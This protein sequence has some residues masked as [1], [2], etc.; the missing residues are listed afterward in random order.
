VL[1]TDG[2][3]GALADDHHLAMGSSWVAGDA[4]YKLLAEADLVLGIGTNFSSFMTDDWKLP[5]PRRLIHLDIDQREVGKNYPTELTLLGDARL[6]L[7]AMSQVLD[8]TAARPPQPGRSH[9]IREAKAQA[10]ARAEQEAASKSW[11]WDGSVLGVLD[12]IRDVVPRN[13]ILML[14]SQ[15][16]YWVARHYPAYEPRTVHMPMAYGSLGFSLPAAIGA[17][18]GLPERAVVSLVGDGAFMFTCQELGTAVQ[19]GLALPILL[20]NDHG[21]GSIRWN[22]KRRY[23]REIA[24]DLTQPDF[25]KLAEA[26]G[27]RA[28]QAATVE[29]LREALREA[30]TASQP[31]LIEIDMAIEP[32]YM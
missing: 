14:D 11:G 15:I 18:V 16:A 2:A 31:T 32:P 24:A 27:M 21:H 8:Q 30:F 5:A 17:K 22:Q 4:I 7:A 9:V 26:F 13:G 3:K 20:Y 6:T 1:T 29:S 12:T 25:L 19:E 28:R 23:G 10:R